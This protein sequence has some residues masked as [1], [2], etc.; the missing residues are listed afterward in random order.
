MCRKL[1]IFLLV[2]LVACSSL[3]AFP[4]RVTASRA[5]ETTD[6]LEA[7]VLPEVQSQ[8]SGTLPEAASTEPLTSSVTDQVMEKVAQGRRLTASDAAALTLELTAL[9][10]DLAAL[11][12]VSA[13]KDALID[14]LTKS[15]GEAGSKAW[16]M[17]DGIAGMRDQKPEFGLG[18]SFGTRLGNSLMMNLGVD[19][20]FMSLD[21]FKPLS[22]ND[23]TFRAGIGWMF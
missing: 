10:E 11:E 13:E 2:L 19:W 20:M 7:E 1:S 17:L 22:M 15:A 16:L 8:D 23:V 4:G 14:A 9:Q 18:L 5:T 21:G 3:W 12:T 6:T